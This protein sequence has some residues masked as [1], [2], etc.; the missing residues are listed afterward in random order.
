VVAV[1]MALSGCALP[2]L[3]IASVQ[4]VHPPGC[5]PTDDVLVEVC[6]ANFGDRDVGAFQVFLDQGRE[7]FEVSSLQAGDEQCSVHQRAQNQVTVVVDPANLIV[8]SNKQNN[9]AV[10][11]LTE[12]PP[13][14][15]CTPTVTP[16]PTW[17]PEP[18]GTS[19]PFRSLVIK[20]AAWS[21]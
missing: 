16:T 12:P 20:V 4:A 5:G 2:D 10:V 21:S 9:S 11:T 18:T 14:V 1:N 8:E 6:V 19:G 13:R 7:V 17:T 3:S 15:T